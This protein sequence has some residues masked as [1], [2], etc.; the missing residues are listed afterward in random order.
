MG[1]WLLSCWP[2][3]G[4]HCITLTALPCCRPEDVV[5][6]TQQAFSASSHQVLQQLLDPVA[7][8][9]LQVSPCG[10]C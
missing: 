4:L 10:T 9:C 7:M 2:R 6:A 1:V 5:A 3:N 8:P